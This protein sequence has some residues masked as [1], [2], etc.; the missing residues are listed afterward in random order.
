MR[1]ISARALLAAAVV[2]VAASVAGCAGV[3]LATVAQL[4]MKGQGY[5]ADADPAQVR[6]ALDVDARIKAAALKPPS[7]NLVLK[8]EG[9]DAGAAF[10]RDIALVPDAADAT[11]LTL[12]A[13]GAGRGWLIY[14]FD[15]AGARQMAELQQRLREMRSAK[16]KGSLAISVKLDGVEEAF[17]QFATT[18]LAT[19]MR[20]ATAD[21]FFKL[22]SG[23]IADASRKA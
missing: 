9:G 19:W 14:G 12:P 1:Q 5:L 4:A 21:G 20:V 11:R 23:R 10:T 3:P 7:L 16:Q 2:A 15:A 17:P 13:A 18:E 6:I 22:W 8:P